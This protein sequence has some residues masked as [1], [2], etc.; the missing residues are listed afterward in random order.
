MKVYVTLY[1][2]IL[3]KI[4]ITSKYSEKHFFCGIIL[5]RDRVSITATLKKF[6]GRE[7]K[8]FIALKNLISKLLI[9]ES[10]KLKTIY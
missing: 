6:L 9:I 8:D 4:Q 7:G 1:H 10:I 3:T 5:E 2:F